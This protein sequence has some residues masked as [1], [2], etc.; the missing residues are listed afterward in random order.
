MNS[1]N[2]YG[3][4]VAYFK[5]LPRDIEELDHEPRGNQTPSRNL[6]QGPSECEAGSITLRP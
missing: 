3:V 6:N 4:V 1:N 5:H 2:V